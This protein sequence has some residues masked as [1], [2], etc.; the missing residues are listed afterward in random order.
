MPEYACRIA[1][2][3]VVSKVRDSH[4]HSRRTDWIKTTCA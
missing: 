1:L 3:G 2:E 4:Y